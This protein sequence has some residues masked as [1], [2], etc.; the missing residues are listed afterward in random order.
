[1]KIGR[2]EAPSEG[3]G[4]YRLPAESPTSGRSGSCPLFRSGERFELEVE[5]SS[6]CIR[7]RNLPISLRASWRFWPGGILRTASSNCAAISSR[8]SIAAPAKAQGRLADRAD[9]DLTVR[10]LESNSA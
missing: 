2:L 10:R 3:E 6:A 7:L 8:S 9:T 1:M 5:R 4:D